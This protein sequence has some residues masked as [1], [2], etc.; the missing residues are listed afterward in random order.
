MQEY[1]DVLYYAYILHI[2][3]GVETVPFYFSP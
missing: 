2:Y 1:D 3:K